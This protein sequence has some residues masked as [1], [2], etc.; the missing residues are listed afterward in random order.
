MKKF[1][2]K[3]IYMRASMLSLAAFMVFQGQLYAAQPIEHVHTAIDNILQQKKSGSTLDHAT[4]LHAAFTEQK[5]KYIQTINDFLALKNHV[6]FV[7]FKAIVNE[8]ITQYIQH[9]LDP[10]IA[11]N[12][13]AEIK[14]C[15]QQ[16]K[17][18]LLNFAKTLQTYTG[19]SAA[20]LGLK[21]YQSYNHMM[22]VAMVAQNGG[23]AGLV[24]RLGHRL[25][26]TG[27]N[28]CKG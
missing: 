8:S 7:Q 17:N 12:E 6:T 27:N 20:L 22:P 16:F 28:T 3:N 19:K 11:N 13:Y 10:M 2:L 25:R 14:P 24:K 1:L 5:N 18:D 15:L 21:L 26:C 9:V 4:Q 23:K